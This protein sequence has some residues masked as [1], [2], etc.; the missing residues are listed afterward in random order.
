MTEHLRLSSEVLDFVEDLDQSFIEQYTEEGPEML[1]RGRFIAE[2]IKISREEFSDDIIPALEELSRKFADLFAG[3]LDR[4]YVRDVVAAVPGYVSRTLQL[5]GLAAGLK[6]KEVVSKYL[7]EAVRTY[8]FGFPLASIAL[9][10]AVLEHAVKERMIGPPEGAT[11]SAWIEQVADER[12]L[13]DAITDMA[14][15]VTKTGNKVLHQKPVRLPEAFDVLV[16]VRKFLEALYSS[17]P[18]EF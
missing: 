8:I 10:R 14:R 2:Q 6:P 15:S 12:D 17:D 4:L 11:L 3:D 7:A 9:S 5:S 13:D 1:E 18:A 16:K